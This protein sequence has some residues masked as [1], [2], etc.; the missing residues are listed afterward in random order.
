[1]GFTKLDA[2][3]FGGTVFHA[4][5]FGT[6]ETVPRGLIQMLMVS[7][8]RDEASDRSLPSDSR[9]KGIRSGSVVL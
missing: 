5:E 6:L 8:Q 3:N 4:A 2:I 9:S 1:M 7:T